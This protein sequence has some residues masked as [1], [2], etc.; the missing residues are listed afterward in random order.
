M[1]VD[2][3]ATEDIEQRTPDPMDKDAYT[4]AVALLIRDLC[5]LARREGSAS[6]KYGRIF[7]SCGLV[8]VTSVVQN[9]FIIMTKMFVTPQQVADIRSAYDTY[10]T[11]MYANHTT[12]NEHGNHRGMPGFFNIAKFA[13]LSDDNKSSICNIPLAQLW[14]IFL[15][16]LIWSLTCFAQI[17]KC[18][19]RF[20]SLVVMTETR[21]SMGEALKPYHIA[22]IDEQ[23]A[24]DDTT[25]SGQTHVMVIVG[26]TMSMKVLLTL[27]V[28]LPEFCTTS[29]ILWLGSRWLLATNDWSN[30]VSNAVALEFILQLKQLFYYALAS[31]R[32]QRE[33]D[34]T[35][36]A[37]PWTEEPAGF[38][39]YFIAAI[40]TLLAV[41]WVW[42]Y[43]FHFQA[44]LPDYRW[45][46]SEACSPWMFT[47]LS[48]NKDG[49]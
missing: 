28:F 19:E 21:K 38:G 32:M 13:T 23:A 43:V 2:A 29:Y 42:A 15:I 5:A 9:G 17:K 1:I 3:E 14:F 16:L 12:V 10:E 18:I 11:T 39:V 27:L 4:L 26:L 34:R 46:V 47:L 30:L 35:A 44:V 36:M 22:M 37:P 7:Y 41:L 8:F 45:D 40:W 6:L 25:S 48:P 33:L 20:M 49:S 31:E 24:E